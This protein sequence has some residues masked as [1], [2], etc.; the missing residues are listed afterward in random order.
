VSVRGAARRFF[1]AYF[2]EGSYGY[3][4]FVALGLALD[5]LCLPPGPLPLLVFAADAP[6]LWVIQ[7]RGGAHW[8]RWALLYGFLHFGLAV[9]WLAWVTPAHV[10]GTAVILAPVYVLLGL[11]IRTLAAR[12]VPFVLSVGVC[13]VLEEMLRTVWCGGMPWPARS[14]SF[15]GDAALGRPLAAL[16]PAASLFGAYSFSFLAGMGSALVSRLPAWLVERPAGEGRRLLLASLAPFALLL[17]LA[18]HAVTTGVFKAPPAGDLLIVQGNIPQ[19]LKGSRDPEAPRKLFERH[20]RLTREGLAAT[21]ADRHVFA[22]LWPETMIPWQFLDADLA[23]RFPEVWSDEVGVMRR[24]AAEVPAGRDLDWLVGAIYQ[25]RR[26]EERHRSVW[27]YGS[28]DSLFHLDPRRMPGMDDPLPDPPADGAPP[29]RLARHDKTTLVPFGEYTPGGEVIPGLRWLRNRVS[30]IPELD[31]GAEDQA[32]FEVRGGPPG[33]ERTWQVGTVICFELGFPARCRA[34]RRRGAEVLLN[35]GNYGWFGPTDFRHQLQAVTRLRAA[36]L[37]VTV[38]VAGNTGPSAFYGPDG[39]RYG[40]FRTADGEEL[41]A[42]VIPSTFREGWTTGPLQSA[43][44][45]PLYVTW[46]DWPWLVLALGLG[47]WALP[48]RR[49]P[50]GHPDPEPEAPSAH[51]GSG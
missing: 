32:P 21:P 39:R 6:F 33:T 51:E 47:I 2:H 12:R 15:A 29:W 50:G 28:H 26:G 37:G 48:R 11:A 9:R 20:L 1:G 36:E 24:I 16:L 25:F 40:A 31:A 10:L 27:S 35:P 45:T 13:V 17:L 7:Y 30:P 23:A 8:K 18:V 41:E 19:S 3:V 4:G 49:G 14:L 46:G 43:S 5:L 42:G 22:V 34:W 38:V 44:S